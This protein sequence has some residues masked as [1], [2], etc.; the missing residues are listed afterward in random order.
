MK[1]YNQN[2]NGVGSESN[3][4][5][6][7]LKAEDLAGAKSTEP[8]QAERDATKLV[9][10]NRVKED[11]AKKETEAK[12]EEERLAAEKKAKEGTGTAGATENP[13]AV[14]LDG[15][16]YKLNEA[17]D[18]LNEKGEVF[19][20][21]A[22]LDALEAAQSEIP[23]TDEFIQ[24]MGLEILDE[25]G[26]PKKFEDSVEGL[27]EASKE[28]AK[29]IA[30]KEHD[31]I[32]N[33]DPRFKRYYDYLRMGGD[34]K[35]YFAQRNNSW[36]DVKFDENNETQAFNA[37]VA[38]LVKR[39]IA[40]EEAELTANM[41]KDSGKLKEFGKSAHVALIA[42]ED[43]SEKKFKS[44]FEAKQKQD[45]DDTIKHWT[46]VKN[47]ID[48][49][50]LNNITIPDSDRKGFYEWKALN[51]KDG[52]SQADLEANTLPLE[53]LLQLEYLRY[54]KFDFSKLISAAV[55]TEKVKSLRTR[56]ASEQKGAGE[57]EGIDKGKH[58][59]PDTDDISL[60]SVMTGKSGT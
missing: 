1:R 37:V 38:N 15:I 23:V 56:L 20:T 59:K 46:D 14:E 43:A 58:T 40:K 3:N 27:I 22:E 45:H 17:G 21:K 13:Q 9:E 36:K 53:Q 8:S 32:L 55:G 4:L 48:K 34:E 50:T 49:G 35:E 41:Y 25:A 44:D 10:E 31:A 26:K 12:A 52:L 29:I 18:A 7:M 51:V 6:G 39:G 42:D 54:K 60:N 57:G 28:A 30:K 47:I 19:K 11:A 5:D 24:K 16:K 2:I 33:S